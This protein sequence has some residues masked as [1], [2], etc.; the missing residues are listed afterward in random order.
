MKN[1]KAYA[2]S[3]LKKKYN[4]RPDL[5]D[6]R[7]HLFEPLA[8]AVIPDHVDLRPNMTPVEDQGNLGSCT[9][10]AW[11]G[12]VEHLDK[13]NDGHYRNWSRLFVYYNERALRGTVA[14]DAGAF[15]RDGAKA[16]AKW[17]VCSEKAWPYRASR[18]ATK[19]PVSCY[20]EG[21]KHLAVEY[22]RV[23][24]TRADITAALASGLPVV[25]GFTVYESFESDAV[26]T[27][28]IVPMPEKNE[29]ALGGHAVVIV[30]HNI[31]MR[32]FTVRN[33][34]GSSWG[35]RGHFLMP[36]DYVLDPNLSE[37]FWVMKS[38]ANLSIGGK[39]VL[40]RV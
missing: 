13:V 37:D 18:Y 5:P 38:V 1:H 27:K 10:N 28:G 20:L 16:I 25:F 30:G 7:D 32:Q 33:S 39:K 11:V 34:W 21:E 14:E 17:G 15:I 12:A 6:H 24:Q 23:R 9:G 31:P 3:A 29:E 8:D 35:I 4:W 19:P 2:R 22:L 26:A 36:F 40:M